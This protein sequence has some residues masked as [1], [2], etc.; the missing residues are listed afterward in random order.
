MIGRYNTIL[1]YNNN[2]DSLSNEQ[3]FGGY[4]FSSLKRMLKLDFSITQN[5]SRHVCNGLDE[6]LYGKLVWTSN[7]VSDPY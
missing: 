1:N 4:H 6:S 5:N 3:K 2:E 7:V